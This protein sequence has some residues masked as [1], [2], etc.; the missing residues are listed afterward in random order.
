M[1]NS[2]I[3]ERNGPTTQQQMNEVAEN[4]HNWKCANNGYLKSNNQDAVAEQ[5]IFCFFWK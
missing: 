1:N 5:V 4:N 2:G 3:T